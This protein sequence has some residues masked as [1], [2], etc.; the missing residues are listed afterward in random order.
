MRGG[1]V[2][3]FINKLNQWIHNIASILLGVMAVLVILQVIFRFILERPLAFSEELARFSM[4]WLVMIGATVLIR[5]NSHIAVTF[6]VELFPDSLQKVVRILNSILI[7]L[8]CLVL[9]VYGFQLVFDTM[10]QIAP[11]SQIPMGWIILSVPTFG[12]IGILYTIEKLLKEFIPSDN[13]NNA[14]ERKEE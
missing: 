6:F 3:Q 12:V 5:N 10:N 2:L 7:I 1:F 14:A 8:F 4:I 13:D 9:I 11:A